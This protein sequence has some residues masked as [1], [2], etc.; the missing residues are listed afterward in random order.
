MEVNSFADL[1]L[2]TKPYLRATVRC[3]CFHNKYAVTMETVESLG[4]SAQ[5]AKLL[6][7]LPAFMIIMEDNM[8]YGL[9]AT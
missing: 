1:V 9:Q 3:D 4:F 8:F 7:Y 6:A 2:E 5:S